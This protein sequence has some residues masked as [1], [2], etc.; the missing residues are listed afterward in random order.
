MAL[1][2]PVQVAFSDEVRA[3][4]IL[5]LGL[6]SEDPPK[7]LIVVAGTMYPG[8]RRPVSKDMRYVKLKI[9]LRGRY[10]GYNVAILL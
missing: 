10:L 9:G 3:A 1:T 7:D 6:G 8:L 5:I 2:G 4:L